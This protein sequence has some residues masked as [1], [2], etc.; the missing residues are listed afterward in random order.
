[1]T[2]SKEKNECEARQSEQPDGED[3]VR[4][5]K[6]DFDAM[7]AEAD[8]LA[9]ELGQ[10]KESAAKEMQRAD[11]MTAQCQR[12]QAEFENYRKRTNETN[13]RVRQ[14]G[15]VE[16]LEKI[17]PVLDA[18]EQAKKLITDQN[19]LNGVE[20]IERQLNALLE[21]YDV[22]IIPALDLPFDPKFHN[23][24]ME[25]S[26]DDDK[27]G[28]VVRVFQQGYTIGDRVLRYATVIVGK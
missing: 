12:L 22:K 4:M 17:L 11:E 21:N 2:D 23:C 14:D 18:I 9:T 27:K 3:T 24:V 26:A 28:L 16:V 25:E 5:F 8:Q 19:I 7:Q 10:A 15:A 13:K 1:M 6:D 20:M